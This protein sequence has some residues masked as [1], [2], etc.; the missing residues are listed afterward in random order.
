MLAFHAPPDAVTM[1]VTRYGKIPGRIS[2]FQ[3]SMP[4]MRK[5]EQH[6]FKSVGIAIAPA[7]TL[8]RM[9]HCVPKRSSTID[10]IP[11]PPPTRISNSS[12]TGKSA[13]AGTEAAICASGWAIRASRGLK[14][15]ATPAGIV[16]SEDRRVGDEW[17]VPA[18]R[19]AR[20]GK[21][22]G[23]REPRRQRERGGEAPPPA[24]D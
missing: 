22:G 24:A 19:E 10:P 7:I 4:F 20:G 14:P 18:S 5:T 13:V 17:R 15:I 11:S 23:A 16:R 12:T 2:F 8:N 6:S 3:R 1:P 21:G 9:Y